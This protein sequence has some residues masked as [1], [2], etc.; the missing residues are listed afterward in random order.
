MKLKGKWTFK[1]N[2]LQV[3]KLH[4]YTFWN[5]ERKTEVVVF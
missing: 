4:N 2:N 1:L 5:F 3:C